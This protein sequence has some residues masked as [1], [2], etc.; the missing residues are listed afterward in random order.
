MVAMVMV[1]LLIMALVLIEESLVGRWAR[2]AGIRQARCKVE[3]RRGRTGVRRQWKR[4]VRVVR[5]L[6]AYGAAWRSQMC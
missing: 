5:A 6:E 2:V 4:C 1:V 3:G